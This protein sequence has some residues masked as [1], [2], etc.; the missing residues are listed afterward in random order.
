MQWHTK[1]RKAVSISFFLLIES[2][3]L[4]VCHSN[5]VAKCQ[6]NI[7]TVAKSKIGKFNFLFVF[8]WQPSCGRKK[9]KEK[10]IK[11]TAVFSRGTV[12]T[13]RFVVSGNNR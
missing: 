4:P 3:Q 9:S 11:N 7:Q 8:F 2:I 13:E 6:Q 1:T 5:V 10:R 12:Q